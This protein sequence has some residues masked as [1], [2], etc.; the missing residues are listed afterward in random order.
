MKA[1]IN[2]RSL[3]GTHMEIT[4]RVSPILRWRVE[5]A[6]FLLRMAARVLGSTHDVDVNL[7][8]RK[9]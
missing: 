2:L 1:E 7:T 9:P 8:A 4:V 3:K 5:V 6:T